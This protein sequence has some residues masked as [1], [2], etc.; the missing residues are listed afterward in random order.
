[1]L[2]FVFCFLFRVFVSSSSTLLC[3]RNGFVLCLAVAIK[4]LLQPSK[5]ENVPP[6]GA[7]VESSPAGHANP[8]VTL[9]KRLY[10]HERKLSRS[11]TSLHDDLLHWPSSED[12]PR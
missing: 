6:D 10:T 8:A 1:V 2:C 4:Q 3:H 7:T 11:L 12:A 9:Q 5:I